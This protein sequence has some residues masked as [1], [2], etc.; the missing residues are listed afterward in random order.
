M[1]EFLTIIIL[2]ISIAVNAQLLNYV[3]LSTESPGGGPPTEELYA[4]TMQYGTY[5]KTSGGSEWWIAF[6]PAEY[7]TVGSTTEYKTVYWYP[8]D[9]GD[10]NA[11][12]VVD[13]VMT[14]SG[15]GPY[16]INFTNGVNDVG[17]G[18]VKIE[19]SN[20]EVARG[21][22]DG[23]IG[24][25]GVSGTMNTTASNGAVSVTFDV[26]PG[27]TPT[28]TYVYSPMF[29]AGPP[30]YISEG[31]TLDGKTIFVMVHKAA[32]D[33]NF[34]LEDHFDDPS[35]HIEGIYRV[36]TDR[37]IVAG[38]SRGAFFCSTTLLINRYTSIAGYLA[39]APVLSGVYTYAN[40]TDRG[41]YFIAGQ[42][43][44]TATPPHGS[45]LNNF[46][47]ITTYH[48][49]PYFTLYDG[50]GHSSTLWNTNFGNRSTAP[51]DWVAWASLWDLDLDS[52]CDHFVEH[53]EVT[54]DI[55]D[56][57]MAS[58]AVSFMTAGAAKTALESRL[59]T[60]KTTIDGGRRRWYVDAGATSAVTVNVNT[61]SDFDTG[62][63]YSNLPDDA[64]NASTVDFIVV[65]EMDDAGTNRVT[66]NQRTAN[67]G[68]GFAREEY[69]D[70]ARVDFLGG[71]ATGSVKWSGLDD[72][73]TY[74]VVLYA[75]GASTNLS[76]DAF[77][78]ATVGGVTKEEYV[79]FTNTK[80]IEWTGVTPDG[81][82]E[83]VISNIN[84]GGNVTGA[85]EVF[86]LEEEN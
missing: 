15:T 16:T 54:E 74:R 58:R 4:P 79:F 61:A 86:M 52:Q 73:K 70:Y 44:G 72:T 39:V 63:T 37:R 3:N 30:K 42:N 14:G 49:Y 48:F 75:M 50:V 67:P 66:T 24:G 19:V 64:G 20:V 83:I 53:A 82:D 18:T 60:L 13:A 10:G 77:L 17:W 33:S 45:F 59:S 9:G 27:A 51:F 38:L 57:R 46:G 2:L 34:D 6:L 68:F 69:F 7:Q 71:V 21:Q 23:T 81:S 80:K 65:S 78:E 40:Y 62:Q 22:Y 29:E 56:Y 26:T 32:N 28:I 85:I 76:D 25:N 84:N 36:D 31:D 35:T 5:S 55:D 11:T 41:L 1:R 43:D 47:A 8:G 12:E